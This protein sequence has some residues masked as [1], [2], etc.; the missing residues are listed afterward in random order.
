MSNSTTRA[1]YDSGKNAPRSVSRRVHVPRAETESHF[2]PQPL[3]GR[4]RG[5]NRFVVTSDTE[6]ENSAFE[7]ELPDAEVVISQSGAR[8]EYVAHNLSACHCAN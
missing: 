3:H 5:G 7:K 2:A 4:N 6:E 1:Q 8:Y